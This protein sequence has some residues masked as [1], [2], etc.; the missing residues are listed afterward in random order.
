MN[1]TTHI[2]SVRIIY[3][4]SYKWNHTISGLFYDQP[5]ALSL[6]SSRFIC[7]V[8]CVRISFCF[9][10]QSYSIVH[11]D[12][13]VFIYLSVGGHLGCFHLS[14]IVNN[15]AVSIG[16]LARTVIKNIP[17]LLRYNWHITLY[18]FKV[19]NLLFSWIHIL[20]HDY[21]HS[22]SWHLHRATYYHFL[23]VLRT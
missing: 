14:A 21:H 17:V 16:V 9:K 5:I 15:A 18:K 3:G 7:V 22:L 8:T 23:C 4:T 11:I 6:M 20:Y 2:V 13:V 19:C 12:H 1:L 10:A